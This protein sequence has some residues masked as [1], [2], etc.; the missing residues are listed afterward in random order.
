MKCTT[1]HDACE[2]R[3]AKHAE[4]IKRLEFL[5]KEKEDR[6]EPLFRQNKEADAVIAKALFV[7]DKVHAQAKDCVPVELVNLDDM[8]DEY[9]EK[10]KMTK[11][12]NELYDEPNPPTGSELYDEEER[13][14]EPAV[15]SKSKA[16]RLKIQRGA[17]AKQTAAS[18]K[19]WGSYSPA[20]QQ[21][22]GLCSNRGFQRYAE[23][24]CN[25]REFGEGVA[26]KLIL[27]TCGIS[28]R[29]DFDTNNETGVKLKELV[30][31]F[32]KWRE[33]ESLCEA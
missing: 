28:K 3:E 22:I 4:E 5:L 20:R 21:A 9:C 17:S 7:S 29:K 16:K 19:T 27:I 14:G 23:Q 6:L 31:W 18:A 30:E 12:D 13:Y 1:H 24:W 11:S 15:D 32:E 25:Y 10:Y 2:C 33:N 8:I 26:R